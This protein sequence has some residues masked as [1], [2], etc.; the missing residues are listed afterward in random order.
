LPTWL[1][2][3]LARQLLVLHRANRRA[4]DRRQEGLLQLGRQLGRHPTAQVGG[5]VG[6][7]LLP[8]HVNQAADLQTARQVRVLGVNS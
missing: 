3:R 6:G 7:Q 4:V 8:R 2:Q 1:V 5:Q